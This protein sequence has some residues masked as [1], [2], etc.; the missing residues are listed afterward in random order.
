MSE[1]YD[2]PAKYEMWFARFTEWC[3]K[4]NIS[5]NSG[6]S[7]ITDDSKPEP[8]MRDLFWHG[9][10]NYVSFFQLRNKLVRHFGPLQEKIIDQILKNVF[11]MSFEEVLDRVDREIVN[12]IQ[13]ENK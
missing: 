9:M 6:I 3:E 10:H 11:P 4:H 13:E 12:S 1:D 2:F 8:R 5:A 7:I